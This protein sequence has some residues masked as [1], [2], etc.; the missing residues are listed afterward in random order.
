[1]LREF[2]AVFCVLLALDAAW[3]WARADYHDRFFYAVQQ[4]PLRL[5]LLPA[6]G[7]YLILAAAVTQLAVLEA[8]DLQNALLR[9]AIVGGALYAFYDLTNYATLARWTLAMTLTDALWGALAGAA[10]AG[11]VYWML[12]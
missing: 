9:G 12:H 6:V 4:S 5:R 7:V 1:M 8:A 11:G 3:L 10:A 2:G